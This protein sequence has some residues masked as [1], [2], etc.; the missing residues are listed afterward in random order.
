MNAST[1][2][3][4]GMVQRVGFRR[5]A[6]KLARKYR[7]S[8][9]VRNNKDGTVTL[10]VQGEEGSIES[11]VEEIRKAPSPIEVDEVTVKKARTIPSL[12]HFKIISGPLADEMQEGFGGM[13]SEFQDYRQEFRDYKKEFR[14]YREEFRDYRE[15]FGDF[16]QRTD[17]NFKTTDT[18]YGEISSKLSKMLETLEREST[19]TRIELKRS[20][21]R[22][23]ELIDQYINMQRNSQNPTP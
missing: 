16:A 10:F 14:D 1:I 5:F 4:S 17:D 3:I 23:S 19:E 22:L 8:G 2:V 9:Q 12:K 6:E 20:V 7:L 15:E 13:Q 11:L 18:K 21:D